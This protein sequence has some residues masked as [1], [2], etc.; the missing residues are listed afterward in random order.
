MLWTKA[1]QSPEALRLWCNGHRRCRG[2]G[3]RMG[4]YVPTVSAFG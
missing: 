4:R 3:A 2:G 1:L